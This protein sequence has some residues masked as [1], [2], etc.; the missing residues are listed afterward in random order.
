[1][2]VNDPV[3]KIKASQS[4]FS[5]VEV[6]IAMSLM[7]GVGMAIMTMNAQMSA[8]TAKQVGMNDLQDLNNQV[9]ALLSNQD[10]CAEAFGGKSFVPSQLPID[11]SINAAGVSIQQGVKQGL[12]E[13][14]SLRWIGPATSFGNSSTKINGVNYNLSTYSI[15]LELVIKNTSS[16]LKAPMSTRKFSF[17]VGVDSGNIIRSCFSTVDS[18]AVCTQLGGVISNGRCNMTIPIDNTIVEKQP[19]QTEGLMSYV[20]QVGLM[21]CASQKYQK[22]VVSTKCS[23][24]GGV[25]YTNPADPTDRV[26]KI[27]GAA[28]PD[29]M[30]KKENW[31]T[32]TSVHGCGGSTTGCGD[33][34]CCDSG[35]H[36]FSNNPQERC[37][38]RRNVAC[39][40][41]TES[42]PEFNSNITEVGCTPVD[43]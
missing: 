22:I 16:L 28:C 5:L 4:G 13:V 7:V 18:G 9:F 25:V 14:V 11:V 1:M 33:G 40:P 35:Q 15:N 20:E 32:T 39:G 2:H 36:A 30:S 24:L 6:I 26:C 29:G 43:W 31:S 8:Q 21:V 37:F 10:R 12:D 3:Y 34:S 41:V 27:S 17:V 23:N 38:T 42:G 19:C